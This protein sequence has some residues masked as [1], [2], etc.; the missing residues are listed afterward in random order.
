MYCLS[1][2]YWE[3]V[4]ISVIVIIAIL[5]LLRLLVSALGG[6]GP[7]WPPTSPFAQ[8]AGGNP[9]GWVAAALNIIIWAI[10]MIA[11]VLFIFSLIGCLLGAVG[12]F[13]FFPR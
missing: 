4:V 10:I 9:L 3:N 13:H 5:A 8:T 2:A 11:I 7:W 1:L 6:A 12:G